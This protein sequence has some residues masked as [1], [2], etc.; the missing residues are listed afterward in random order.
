M[1]SDASAGTRRERA[2]HFVG[3]RRQIPGRLDEKPLAIGEHD[4]ADSGRAGEA[5]KPLLETL[6]VRRATPR[7]ARCGRTVWWPA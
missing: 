3:V 6:I 4:E 5:L 2:G 7:R 1:P